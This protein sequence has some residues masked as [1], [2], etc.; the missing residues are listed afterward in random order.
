MRPIAVAACSIGLAL[1]CQT[2]P[3]D[4]PPPATNV[5][6]VSIDTLRADHLGAYGY[7]PPT[8][9]N[10]DAF[11]GDAVRFDRAFAHAPSTLI[12]HASL[13]TSEI[14]SHHGASYHQFQAV[15]PAATTLT[16]TL[17]EHG[18]RSFAVTGGGQLASAYGLDR[19]F[20]GYEEQPHFG[21]AWRRGLE[22]LDETGGRPFFL[23]LH[24][25][26]VHHP[27]Q[28]TPGSLTMMDAG[29]RGTL[30]PDISVGLLEAVNWK[31][32]HLD[33]ADR[34]H[35]VAAYDAGIR[36]V[37]AEFG[38]LIEELRRRHLYDDTLIVLVSDHGEEFME[39]GIIGWHGH[40]LYDELL[41]IPLIVKL[42]GR[43][44]AG[45]VVD[46]PVRGIDLAPTI[47]AI[48]GIA[49]PETFDGQALVPLPAPDSAAYEVLLVQREPGPGEDTGARGIR[50]S[51]WMT[52]GT[53]LFDLRHDPG[54]QH[55]IGRER[56]LLL[57][58]LL[59]E[60]RNTV[61]GRRVAEGIPFSPTQ[62][63]K[64]RLR[65]LGYIGG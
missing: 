31:G 55:D 12:S 59:E 10:I 60:Q 27:Y 37:D 54:E 26:D 20:E 11:A 57:R 34:A 9:P 19:G 63:L 15:S 41:R 61:A 13:F 40:T 52:D 30:P 22:W 44:D 8:S 1:A 24:T 53:H 14:P 50:T 65:S 35:I 58:A 17:S 4:P 5:V 46:A 7:G 18:Y 21:S 49:P 45:R 62:A 56:P 38:R 25:Y 51:E 48:A 42:P 43:R 28:P 32:R 36:D 33:A 6:L 29:Y 47:L 3:H 64:D 16:E 23:F 2:R 39:H